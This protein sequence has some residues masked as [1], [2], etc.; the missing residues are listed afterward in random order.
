MPKLVCRLLIAFSIL[1]CMGPYCVH[2][3]PSRSPHN[4]SHDL[5]R[6]N[7]LDCHLQK[8]ASSSTTEGEIQGNLD[9]LYSK[10]CQKCH[11]EKIPRSCQLIASKATSLILLGQVPAFPLPLFQNQISCLSCHITHNVPSKEEN[12]FLLR[13][14]YDSFLKLPETINPHKSG[15]FCFLCHEKEP[16]PGDKE[17]HLKSG[18]VQICKGCHNNKRARADNHPV[19]IAPSKERGVKVPDVVPLENGK[20]SCVS[21]HQL[22]CQ[23]QSKTQNSFFLRGGPYQRRIDTCLV[24]H[25]R[26]QYEKINPHDQ[27][28]DTGEIRE[29][30]C[31]F[32]H[33]INKENATGLAFKFKAPFKFYCLGCHPISVEKH[34]FGAHHTGR[35]LHAIWEGIKPSERTMLSQ[36][37]RFKMFPISISGEIMCATC[38]NP[39]DV[40]KGSKLRI[41]DVNKSCRQCHYKKYGQIV[42]GNAGESGQWTSQKET[43]IRAASQDSPSQND[44]APAQEDKVSFGYRASLNYYCIGCHA[45]KE[46]GHPYGV[47]HTGKFVKRFYENKFSHTDK[48][49]GGQGDKGTRGQG[50]MEQS[51]Q[52]LFI[53]GGEGGILPDGSKVTNNT[54]N[55]SVMGDNQDMQIFPLTLSGQIGCFTCHNP[56]SGAKGPKL[57]V[58]SKETLCTLCHPNRSGII[59]KYLKSVPKQQKQEP[60][61]EKQEIEQ[62][63]QETEKQKQGIEQQTQGTEQQKQGSVNAK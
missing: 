31:L 48:G 38:H 18:S 23:G 58:E 24:C 34:P 59:E 6:V 54:S 15:V 60:E 10:K 42:D 19:G 13:K 25:V 30:R 51:P 1:G 37:D 22:S 57:R 32:C 39:H 62:Q 5:V 3:K 27:V 33:D 56:H 52:P 12:P 29:D 45:N 44:L 26:E 8:P 49:T 16:R 43:E 7:C 20:L 11:T 53:K 36:Q 2:A 14:A 63:K 61:K 35:Q 41:N 28:T 9:P 17:L 40:R 50:D 4:N 55:D 46:T 47:M 21:C